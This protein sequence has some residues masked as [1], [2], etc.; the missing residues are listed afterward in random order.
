MLIVLSK[1]I[2]IIP[3]TGLSC[4]GL[5]AIKTVP[6]LY[7]YIRQHRTHHAVV[8]GQNHQILLTKVPT[9]QRHALKVGLMLN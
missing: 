2:T 3:W 8:T 9:L 4:H 5:T 7:G 6:G 1:I